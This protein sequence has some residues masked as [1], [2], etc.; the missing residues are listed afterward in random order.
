MTKLSSS[1]DYSHF[2]VM[3]DEV[4]KICS[5]DRGGTFIDCTFG[6]GGYSK[7]ILNFSKTKVIALDRD[8]FIQNLTKKLEK[9][10][11]GRFCFYH[12]KFSELNSIKIEQLVD[13]VI[14]DLGIS[15]IQLKNLQRGFSFNS[16]SRL[17]MSM[18]L[19]DIS[20]ERVINNATEQNLKLI[21]KILGEEQEANK[22]AR[23]IIIERKKKEIVNVSQL[24]DIIKKSKKKTFLNKINPSTKTFQALRIFVNK[25][26]TELIKGIVN[27]TKILK[28]GG[29]ILIVSFH[30]IE[31]KI[32]KYFFNNYSSN[33]SKP[34]RYL[35][36][37]NNTQ[38]ILFKKYKNQILKPTKK[39]IIKNPP[40]R[41]AK[42]RY[43]TRSND[44][45]FYPDDLFNKFKKYLDLEA[46]HV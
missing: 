21:I 44:K 36:E 1:P 38:L 37:S 10:Y 16:K 42:L 11:P 8:N 4:I 30:S 13:G 24:V 32:V 23:N 19:S 14:F 2:P 29:V 45:F 6:G 33:K 15:S 31:D 35:P 46:T 22:I 40:S 3:L 43:A 5:P 26:I 39:E 18:G 9:K 12:K 25:E 28:P 20:A 27:A 7:E 41:S 34:S 17:D